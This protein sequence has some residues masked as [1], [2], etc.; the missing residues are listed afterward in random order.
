M[1]IE[2]YISVVEEGSCQGTFI[3]DT[4]VIIPE[5]DDDSNL[6][7]FCKTELRTSTFRR[8]I[9]MPCKDLYKR[10]FIRRDN[11][12]YVKNTAK[13]RSDILSDELASSEQGKND[14]VSWES[15]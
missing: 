4:D 11:G 5:L 3:L 8:G 7:V 1:R 6:C 12:R 15:L 9:C 2:H 14:D 10:H 13:Q